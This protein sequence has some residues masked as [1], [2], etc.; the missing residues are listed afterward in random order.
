MSV[1]V[2]LI[3]KHARADPDVVSETPI[4]NV[5]NFHAQKHQTLEWKLQKPVGNREGFFSFPCSHLFTFMTPLFVADSDEAMGKGELIQTQ[6]C[7]MK[8]SENI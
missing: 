7:A 5:H 8:Q 3:S 4:L 1:L 6:I 2:E